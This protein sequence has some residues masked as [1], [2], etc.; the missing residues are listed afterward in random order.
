MPSRKKPQQPRK[1]RS[2]TLD[3]PEVPGAA[4]SDPP[5]VEPTP[6]RLRLTVG[7]QGATP[8]ASATPR[9]PAAVA[10]AGTPSS[11]LLLRPPK[12]PGPQSSDVSQSSHGGPLPRPSQLGSSMPPP[13]FPSE[14]DIGLG[15]SM[16]LPRTPIR[17]PSTRLEHTA[18]G[19]QRISAAAQIE[20][21][22]RMIAALEDDLDEARFPPTQTFACR[23]SRPNSQPH[24]DL[25]IMIPSGGRGGTTQAN[26]TQASTQ[27]SD[28]TA[29]RRVSAS[30]VRS[31]K[32]DDSE[33]KPVI[34]YKIY[35]TSYWEGTKSANEIKSDIL[36]RDINGPHGFTLYSCHTEQQEIADRHAIQHRH[37]AYRVSVVAQPYYGSLA[38]VKKRKTNVDTHGDWVKVLEEL[39]D[40]YE[41]KKKDL[42]V[43][44]VYLFARTST[45]QMAP[46]PVP[47]ATRR[48]SSLAIT[49]SHAAEPAPSLPANNPTNRQL[50]QQAVDEAEDPA[51]GRRRELTSRWV[52]TSKKCTLDSSWCWV[53]DDGKH[54]PLDNKDIMHWSG[55]I[56][57]DRSGRVTKEEPPI[58]IKTDI[59]K[60]W[61]KASKQEKKQLQQAQMAPFAG[62]SAVPTP[63]AVAAPAQAPIIIQYP[64]QQASSTPG[65]SSVRTG[66][67]PNELRHRGLA[68]DDIIRERSGSRSL[69]ARTSARPP[70]T[71]SARTP[72]P[73]LPP[74]RQSS[75]VQGD[76]DEYVEWLAP[77]LK[78]RDR[79]ALQRARDT[80]VEKYYGTEDVQPWKDCD[81]RWERIS[82]RISWRKK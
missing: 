28:S 74:A 1:R 15:F 26:T 57:R 36:K 76:L 70:A 14:L 25:G 65:L 13:S 42:A 4:A 37:P 3:R 24:T 46:P 64:P 18:A 60:K 33:T 69:A 27:A 19:L 62:P 67:I 41:Q 10:A 16:G 52:C 58:S 35:I 12:P 29:S 20:D 49:G 9:G 6:Q 81:E 17:R 51:S 75:P 55:L 5:V 71:K 63:A 82:L 30:P 53:N 2:S 59:M 54:F 50:S 48:P 56:E 21:Q 34:P 8:R 31:D 80:L 44:L 7:G 11:R 78:E 73:S 72:A 22:D 47:A 77:Q 39:T 79:E 61:C 45:G 43:D 32:S 38:A 66:S 23:L 68:V 40:W